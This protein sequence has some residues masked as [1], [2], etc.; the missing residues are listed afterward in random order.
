M[1]G[2]FEMVNMC[3]NLPHPFNSK[4]MREQIVKLLSSETLAHVAEKQ[5]NVDEDSD[6]ESS[7]EEE[8]EDT[9]TENEAAVNLLNRGRLFANV[10][11]T[12]LIEALSFTN[13]SCLPN[14]SVDFA[15]LGS[16][17]ADGPGLWVY[18]DARRP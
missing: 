10:V 3:I 14:C 9:A 2:T 12:A 8:T 11:G 7:E 16:R 6:D 15:T 1:L 17:C 4:D 18:A 13:H 5:R